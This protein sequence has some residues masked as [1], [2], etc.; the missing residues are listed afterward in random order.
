MIDFKNREGNTQKIEGDNEENISFNLSI[1][2]VS[3]IRKIWSK[4]KPFFD[5]NQTES[6]F[7]LSDKDELLK[8]KNKEAL[9]LNN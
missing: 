7:N 6:N 1:R 3:F 4:D 5:T 8:Y 9:S 2:D